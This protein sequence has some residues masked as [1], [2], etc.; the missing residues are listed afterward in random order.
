MSMGRGIQSS[1][2]IAR[3]G[4]TVFFKNHIVDVEIASKSTHN[5]GLIAE[6]AKAMPLEGL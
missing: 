3:H 2:M 6:V 1:I 5:I 4:A